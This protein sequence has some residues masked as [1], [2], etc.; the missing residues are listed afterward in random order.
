MNDQ[1]TKIT[2]LLDRIR[3]LMS[4]DITSRARVL[5]ETVGSVTSFL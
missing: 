4:E 2:H 1:I 3:L 5:I